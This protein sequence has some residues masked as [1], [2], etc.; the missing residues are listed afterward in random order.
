M[1]SPMRLKMNN[2]FWVL[3]VTLVGCLFMVILVTVGVKI[4]NS[5]IYDKCL[6]TNSSMVYNDLTKMCKEVVK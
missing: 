1:K 3:P 2:G 5:R 6:T 4:E